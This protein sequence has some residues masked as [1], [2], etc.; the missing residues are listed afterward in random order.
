[1][2]EGCTKMPK[3]FTRPGKFEGM[4]RYYVFTRPTSVHHWC[5]LITF[6]CYHVQWL[7][8]G[9]SMCQTCETTLRDG[10]SV[11]VCPRKV[12][13]P[14]RV[15]L[16]LRLTYYSSHHRPSIVPLVDTGTLLARKNKPKRPPNDWKTFG[17][18]ENPSWLPFPLHTKGVW[19]KSSAVLIC[20]AGTVY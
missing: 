7:T 5:P 16:R 6:R 2:V 12:R 18:I 20:R 4:P 19:G 17:I 11:P 13:R 14:L 1:M 10:L 3:R 15:Y 9:S 8:F